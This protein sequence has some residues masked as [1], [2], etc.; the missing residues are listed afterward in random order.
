MPVTEVTE[1]ERKYEVDDAVD[2]PDL[3]G[4][5]GVTES[6]TEQPVTLRAVYFDTAGGALA[7]AGAG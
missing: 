6:R 4:V 5:A 3:A 7:S 1:T 2:V